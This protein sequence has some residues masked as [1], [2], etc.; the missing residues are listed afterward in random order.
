MVW[1]GAREKDAARERKERKVGEAER[2]RRGGEIERGAGLHCIATVSSKH[3][4]PF[5]LST[6]IHFVLLSAPSTGLQAMGCLGFLSIS[7]STAP[8]GGS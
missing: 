5:S 8:W 7:C 1:E 6:L 3:T 4:S 2:G